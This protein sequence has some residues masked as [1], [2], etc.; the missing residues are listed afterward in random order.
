MSKKVEEA[1]L[2]I[3]KRSIECLRAGKPLALERWES[4]FDL[5]PDEKRQLAAR[6]VSVANEILNPFQNN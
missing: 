1:L 5:T 6:L 2:S 3:M 4:D